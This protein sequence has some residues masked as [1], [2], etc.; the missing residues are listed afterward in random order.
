SPLKKSLKIEP[1]NNYACV[2]CLSLLRH[3]ALAEG[4]L[5]HFKLSSI[6]ELK[7][8][9]KTGRLKVYAAN[10]PPLFPFI[11]DRNYIVSSF[12]PSKKFKF[13]DLEKL[14]FKYSQFDA[15][16]T[17]DILEHVFDLTAALTEIERVLRPGGVH[18]FT[19]PVNFEA[20]RTILRAVKG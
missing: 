8:R 15:V 13:Q 4:F 3:R 18:F 10:I 12:L 9:L 14:T 20:E 17:C 2:S 7:A 1:R 6:A 16:I 5:K 11:K 19:L